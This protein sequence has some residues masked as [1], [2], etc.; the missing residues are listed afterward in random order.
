MQNSTVMIF[1]S[2]WAMEEHWIKVQQVYWVCLFICDLLFIFYIF[3]KGNKIIQLL[4]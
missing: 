3:L 1:Q 4:G 2:K